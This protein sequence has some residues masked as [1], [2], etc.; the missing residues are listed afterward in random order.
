MKILVLGATGQIGA[1]LTDALV[2]NGHDVSVLV[3]SQGRPFA[4]AVRVLIR[5]AFTFDA[6]KEALAE[7]DHVLY[8]VG[9]P[10]QFRFDPAVFDDVNCKLLDTF[11]AA[12]AASNVQR[13]TYLS[14]YEVFA[15]VDDVIRERNPIADEAH[16]TPYFQ[17][18]IR[19][20]RTVLE[21]ARQGGIHLTTIHPAAVYGGLNTGNG[22]S[23]YMENLAAG[24]ALAV[25]F[26]GET[27]FPVVHV[28]S[29]ARAIVLSLDR[30]GSYIISDGM[31]SLHEIAQVMRTQT[32]SYVPW[33]LPQPVVD[34]GVYVL[35]SVARATGI[36]PIASRVQIA[37][38][39]KDWRPVSDKA[40]ADLAWTPMPLAD[41]IERVLSAREQR[42]EKAAAQMGRASRQ[43]IER[44]ALLQRATA[45]GLAFY[46]VAYYTIG[47]APEVPPPGYFTYQNAFTYADLILAALLAKASG[48]LGDANPVR[49]RFGYGLSLVCAG[50]LLFL[51]G[52]D[53][54]FNMQN[55][56]YGSS[57]VNTLREGAINLWC[58]GFGLLS[59]LAFLP[60]LSGQAE[61][62]D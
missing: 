46:W 62:I 19:A 59:I 18:M 45:L 39:T 32:N 1:A 26:I 25:P 16:M 58:I 23:D 47:L 5:A 2:G 9:L 50:A 34:A 55:G 61:P 44:I 35:E 6:F 22:I 11:L 38:L 49:K 28:A 15:I 57:T 52:L 53:I 13:L 10:E 29:L 4:S 56:I 24:N 27:S 48:L 14:T 12:L 3:R 51:G 36:K 37:F 7:I 30:P 40:Q 41:G 60:R 21:Q 33:R 8:C 43:A 17:S 31:T 54:T 42:L 20:Y